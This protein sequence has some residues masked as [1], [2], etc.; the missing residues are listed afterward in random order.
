MCQ[1]KR[2]CNWTNVF[3][4]FYLRRKLLWQDSCH[5]KSALGRRR[6]TEMGHWNLVRESQEHLHPLLPCV[7]GKEAAV[8]T[9]LHCTQKLSPKQWN[10]CSMEMLKNILTS[11]GVSLWRKC[12]LFLFL[13]DPVVVTNFF[14]LLST[15]HD[16]CSWWRRVVWTVCSTH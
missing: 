10:H 4:N 14:S 11:Y 5:C 3:L 1:T 13:M 9:L 6:N 12:K 7:Q 15:N 8:F 2:L 16:F